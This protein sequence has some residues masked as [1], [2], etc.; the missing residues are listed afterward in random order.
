MMLLDQSIHQISTLLRQKNLSSVELVTEAYQT[1]KEINPQI[2]AFITLV[3]QNL[4]LKQARNVDQNRVK[5]TSP[6]AG[7]PYLLKDSYVTQSLRTTAASAVLQNFIPPYSATVYHRLEDSGAILIGKM[8]MDAWGHGG[9][10][11]NTDFKPTKNPYELSRVAGGSSGGPA[12]A[13]ACR[14]AAFAIGE[15]TGGSIRNPAAWTNTTGLKVTYGRVS[16]YGCIAYAS[17]FD[18]VGPMAKTAAD[19]A[20]V[21]KAIAGQDPYDATSA[22]QPV[23]DYYQ[24]LTQSL[25]GKT[26][27]IPTDLY[28]DGLDEPIKTAILKQKKVFQAL[29]LKLVE[30]KMPLLRYGLAVY[31]LIGLSETS[32]NLARYDGLRFGQD[33]HFFTTETMRRIMIGTYALSAG[34]YDAYYRQAQKGRTLLIREYDQA[35]THCDVLL[36]P[37]NPISPPKFGELI[38]DPLTN[39]MAD[40]YTVTQNPVGLPSLAVPCGFTPNQLPIGLQL[41]GQLFAEDLLLAIGHQYQQV[42]TWHLQKPQLL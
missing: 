25:K 39:I 24:K 3:E 18:T 33:R 27:G 12:A 9:S 5:F 38:A 22:V 41:V 35:F 21:L 14:L 6:L 30:L 15:D 2:N 16:R 1:I 26:I 7:I 42:T 40:I 13:L 23:P 32:S 37:V 34:Y 28:G 29:G 17:S 19:C 20:L 4:A 8:N 36:M 31:Y 11:E 10:T